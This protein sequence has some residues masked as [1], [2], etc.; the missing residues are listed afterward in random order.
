MD[1]TA[2]VPL[3]LRI[4]SSQLDDEKERES[5]LGLLIKEIVA[6]VKEKHQCQ[7]DGQRSGSGNQV[8]DG[9]YE[10]KVGFV[11]WGSESAIELARRALLKIN[12]SQ[13]ILFIWFLIMEQ[14]LNNGSTIGSRTHKGATSCPVGSSWRNAP[15]DQGKT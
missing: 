6:Y 9:I 2:F 4:N 3:H 12:V 13:V 1:G 5:A 10:Y 8:S 7:I 14:K 11:V 15:R